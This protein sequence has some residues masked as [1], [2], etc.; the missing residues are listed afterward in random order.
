M[1]ARLRFCPTGK[2]AYVSEDHANMDARRMLGRYG[3]RRP[4]RCAR[5]GLWHLTSRPFRAPR[6]ANRR[7]E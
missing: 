7:P 4:Y 2:L 5:C 3:Y 6:F 1:T